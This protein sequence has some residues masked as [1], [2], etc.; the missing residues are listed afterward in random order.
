MFDIKHAYRETLLRRQTA[1]IP[2]QLTGWIRCDKRKAVID[3]HQ[4]VWLNVSEGF[5]RA[6]CTVNCYVAIVCVVHNNLINLPVISHYQPCRARSRIKLYGLLDEVIICPRDAGLPFHFPV[7]CKPGLSVSDVSGKLK[8]CAPHVELHLRALY[9]YNAD[10]Y[11][12]S[13][14]GGQKP[15]CRRIAEGPD[16]GKRKKSCRVLHTRIRHTAAPDSLKQHD[17]DTAHDNSNYCRLDD[18]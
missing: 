11:H 2:E 7:R 17:H 3:T 9:P 15:Y 8:L 12:Q 13:D 18:H 16:Y 4:D 1:C 5:S 6:R 10:S 14:Y